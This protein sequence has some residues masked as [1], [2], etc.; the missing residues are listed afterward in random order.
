MGRLMPWQEPGAQPEFYDPDDEHQSRSHMIR[1]AAVPVDFPGDEYTGEGSTRVP[2]PITASERKAPKRR[3]GPR[4]RVSVQKN[5]RE[6]E[7][8]FARIQANEPRKFREKGE[9]SAHIHEDSAELA[10]GMNK[11]LKKVPKL[12]G[13]KQAKDVEIDEDA[14]FVDFDAIARKHKFEVYDDGEDDDA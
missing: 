8:A 11:S 12:K 7:R 9:L 5:T 13:A 14:T 6:V 4:R 3:S 10:G 1:R 2:P